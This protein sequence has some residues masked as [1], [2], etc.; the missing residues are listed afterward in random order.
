M[1]NYLSKQDFLRIYREHLEK[2][3]TSLI[4][5]IKAMLGQP[6]N[7]DGKEISVEVF[8][9]EYGKGYVSIGMYFEG[10]NKKVDQNDKSFFPGRYLSFAEYANNLPLIDVEAYKEEFC[11]ADVT[12]Q[13]V[14]NGLF[15]VGI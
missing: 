11:I 2:Y 8:P 13:E 9:D 12:V 6:V 4:E 14:I 1:P 10:K 15:R 3:S 5:E 7:S